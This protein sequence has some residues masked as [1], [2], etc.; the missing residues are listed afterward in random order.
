MIPR[1]FVFDSEFKL[2][3]HL[4]L[5]FLQI[6]IPDAHFICIGERLPNPR[7]RRVESPFDHDRFRHISFCSHILSFLIRLRTH[8]AG[9]P[10]TWL[11]PDPRHALLAPDQ[12]NCKCR[13][14]C[15]GRGRKSNR[16]ERCHHLRLCRTHSAQEVRRSRILPSCSCNTLCSSSP[17][18]W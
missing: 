7:H 18:P 10:K 5:E 1:A 4:G 13:L 15:R 3:S 2:K 14:K 17:L 11:T 9:E 12:G 8:R 6:E 16:C